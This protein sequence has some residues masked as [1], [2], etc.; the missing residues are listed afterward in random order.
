M[1]CIAITLA[2]NP[3]QHCTYLTYLPLLRKDM[4]GVWV[5]YPFNKLGNGSSSFGHLEDCFS[6]PVRPVKRFLKHSNA[7]SVLADF[8]YD[9]SAASIQRHRLDYICSCITKE[10][11]ASVKVNGDTIHIFQGGINCID[12]NLSLR[13][14]KSSSLYSCIILLPV[15]PEH[16]P[17]SNTRYKN[18]QRAGLVLLTTK[19]YIFYVSGFI[20]YLV[21]EQVFTIIN[22]LVDKFHFTKVMFHLFPFFFFSFFIIRG[23]DLLSNISKQNSSV[24]SGRVPIT[25]N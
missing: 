12:Y 10:E 20:I 23:L 1:S 6:V 7:I 15:S 2:I 16:P 3:V 18:T 22:Y 5:V 13:S 11:P 8:L 21:L 24:S 25:R 19:T 14:I 9:S 4:Q 17:A